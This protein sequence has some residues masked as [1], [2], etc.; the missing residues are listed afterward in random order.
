MAAKRWADPQASFEGNYLGCLVLDPHEEPVGSGLKLFLQE[1]SK[2]K[3]SI[4]K[5]LRGS[6]SAITTSCIR[7]PKE[8]VNPYI[9]LIG[10][11][12]L[13]FWESSEA[14]SSCRE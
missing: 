14:N 7:T 3:A 5:T 6:R 11:S 9:A 1:S 2:S 10:K 8:Y 13:F 12:L 4:L